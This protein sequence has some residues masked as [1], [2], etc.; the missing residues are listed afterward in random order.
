MT[1]RFSEAVREVDKAMYGF[2]VTRREMPDGKIA[3]PELARSCW[4]NLPGTRLTP[5]ITGRH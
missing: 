2:G 4:R 3:V 5:E 1:G